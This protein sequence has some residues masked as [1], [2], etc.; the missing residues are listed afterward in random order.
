MSSNISAIEKKKKEYK[1]GTGTSPKTSDWKG[2][3]VTVLKYVIYLAL[4]ALI[5]A[6]FIFFTSN[7]NLDMFFPSTP[8]MYYPISAEEQKGGGYTCPPKGSRK[9]KF[10]L[11]LGILSSLG[12]GKKLVGWPYSL[13]KNNTSGF[14]W[15]GWKNWFA[16]TVGNSYMK[17]I[18]ILK[19]IL[20]YFAPSKPGEHSNMFA[21]QPFQMILSNL[22]FHFISMITFFMGFGTV[23]FKSFSNKF[24]GW[25]WSLIGLFFGFT[26][27]TTFCTASIQTVQMMATLMFLPLFVSRK[28]IGEIIQCNVGFLSAVFGLLV[29]G[30]GM[31]YLD[32]W[33]S[34]VMMFAYVILM[35]KQF[36]F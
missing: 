31:Q 7:D 13:H 24:W 20:R 23:L 29:V 16:T 19:H 18:A 15:N 10:G 22:V 25:Q 14:S 3:F 17:E 36:F 21:N 35:I 32:Y 26:W 30:A 5:G 2:F 34:T 4:F 6:N 1:L 11:D 27:I 9:F 8:V 33:T 12:I 28:T